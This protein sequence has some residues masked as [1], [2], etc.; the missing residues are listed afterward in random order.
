MR[1]NAYLLLLSILMLS[2]CSTTGVFAPVFDRS[3]GSQNGEAGPGF[4]LVRKGD[5][6]GKI[7]A[8]FHV[9]RKDLIKWNNLENPNVLEVGRRL[10]VASPDAVVTGPVSEAAVPEGRPLVE[11]NTP[12]FKKG[13]KGGVLPY[14][15]GTWQS[16][17]SVGANSTVA[18]SSQSPTSQIGSLPNDP[19]RAVDR[20]ASEANTP[21]PQAASLQWSL[22]AKGKVLSGFSS[23]NGKGMDF[24]GKMGDPVFAA[25]DGKVSYVGNAVRG[26]GKLVVVKHNESYLSVYA[27]NSKIVVKDNQTVKRGQK[28]AEMGNSD[29]DRVKLHFEIR[30]D[31][32]PVDPARFLLDKTP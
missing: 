29:S 16:L 4:Y 11:A 31:G 7:A 18:S 26:L 28:I 13:P 3:S 1:Q 8:D 14:S 25:A 32:L 17:N 27:H 19:S 15:T 6:L 2:A 23:K 22:P 10:R 5:T 21:S 30:R 20:T 24:D 9:D 12:Q